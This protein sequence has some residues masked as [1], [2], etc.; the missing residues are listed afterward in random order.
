MFGQRH[1]LRRR[2]APSRKLTIALALAGSTA[3][4]VVLVVGTVSQISPAS[5]PYRRT[6]N[7]SFAALSAPLVAESSS[8]AADLAAVLR[9]GPSLDR[10]AFFGDLDTLA[11]ST[12]TVARGF[13]AIV[14]PGPIA[15]EGGECAH[16]LS[17]REA[18]TARL[19]SALE[20]LLGG[21][22]GEGRGAGDEAPAVSAMQSV[23][24]ALESDDAM[25]A[26]CRTSLARS[27]GS[28]RL[29]ESVW[30]PD[31]SVWTASA[32]DEFVAGVVGSATLA[33]AHDLTVMDEVTVPAPLQSSA[34]TVVLPPTTAISVR[35]VIA[36][37]GNVDE[38]AVTVTDSVAGASSPV[39]QSAGGTTSSHT[40]SLRI[41]A[42][43][44]ASVTLPGLTV[45]PGDSYT[46]SVQATTPAGTSSSAASSLPIEI[47]PAVT[48]T[49][50]LTS[51]SAIATGRSVTYTAQISAS[52]G[53]LP[54]PKGT[55]TFQ[56][57]GA[58]IPTCPS[59]PVSDAKATCSVVYPAAA[60][61]AITAVYSG[62]PSRSA[63]T[64]APLI[65]K[66]TSAPSSP[67]GTSERRRAVGGVTS[68]PR[69]S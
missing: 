67:R 12:Q 15:P 49:G 53:G 55:V 42:G 34:G 21:T 27:A 19:R 37:Q 36:D 31:Q 28:A 44:A 9:S 4:V 1:R 7:R 39:A 58:T 3:V 56:D 24:S 22:T 64:S 5:G 26:A 57:D 43:A 33:A 59:Q 10:A 20:G 40:R 68:A 46:L 25:W 14:S 32:L 45:A 17:G 52:P 11:S 2:S 47:S 48:T 63:S 54:P 62:D 60:V 30:V 50:L 16:A 13:A 61:H 23:G 41:A 51:A 35:V 38:K 29:K 8:S 66:V 65:E 69:A 18:A 6:V